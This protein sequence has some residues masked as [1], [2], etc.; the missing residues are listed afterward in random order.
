MPQ[1]G[2]IGQFWLLGSGIVLCIL[3]IACAGAA[4]GAATVMDDALRST[5]KGLVEA[6]G[7]ARGPCAEACDKAAS[8]ELDKAK[9]KAKCATNTSAYDMDQCTTDLYKAGKCTCSGSKPDTCDCSGTDIGQIKTAWAQACLG[10][11]LI[12]LAGGIVFTG[13]PALVA[14]WKKV[15]I[16][17][18]L[19]FSICSGLWTVLFLAFGA[20]FILVGMY[21]QGPEVKK[22]MDETCSAELSKNSND[23]AGSAE[24]NQFLDCGAKALCDG[25]STLIKDTSDKSTAVSNL[26]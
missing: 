20:V 14:A 11:G 16:V 2:R 13:I 9:C 1:Q 23:G 7:C 18:V 6:V 22:V 19:C 10:L 15:P 3:A 24:I 21:L 5:C 4:M 12:A 25:W 26:L 17:N 8:N